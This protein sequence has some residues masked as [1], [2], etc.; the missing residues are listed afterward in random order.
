MKKNIYIAG[1]ETVAYE[2]LTCKNITV[3]GELRIN[4]TLTATN[5]GGSG[6]I[7]A[8]AI[9]AKTVRADVLDADFIVADIVMARHIYAT[10]VRAKERIVAS[11]FLE[12]GLVKA[13]KVTIADAEIEDVQ[14]DELVTIS[15]KPHSIFG[16]LILSVLR[17]MWLS[18]FGSKAT[19][20]Q[21]E[22]LPQVV[23]ELV[24]EDGEVA[25]ESE[26]DHA[27]EVI[28]PA[29]EP[30]TQEMQ[31]ALELLAD[32]QFRRLMAMRK[33]QKAHGGTWMLRRTPAAID[34]PGEDFEEEHDAAA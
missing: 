22:Q 18:V 27:S 8:S 19:A 21:R 13:P 20:V 26:S 1:G 9:H 12:A 24:A 23:A 4:G 17:S 14:T 32:P 6:V 5:I 11:S 30:I 34:I 10:E 28:A 31:D 33:M 7:K 15:A 2:N 16:A 3:D 25:A 29:A